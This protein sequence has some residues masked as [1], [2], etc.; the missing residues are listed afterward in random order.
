MKVNLTQV[1]TVG[2]VY[3][4]QWVGCWQVEDQMSETIQTTGTKITQYTLQEGKTDTAVLAHRLECSAL[5]D[6]NHV[7]VYYW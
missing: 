1:V 7:T 5:P 2:Q 6:N 4:S 3:T